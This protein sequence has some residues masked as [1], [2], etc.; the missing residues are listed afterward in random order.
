[1]I[2]NIVSQNVDVYNIFPEENENALRV[3]R[4]R[5]YANGNRKYDEA[6]WSIDKAYTS[7]EFEQKSKEEL[8]TWEKSSG[9][10]GLV[11][12][13]GYEVIDVDDNQEGKLIYNIL[14]AEGLSFHGI[15]TPNGYQFIFKANQISE[16]QAA[17]CLTLAGFEV[18]YR[19]PMKGYI[20]L[21]RGNTEDREWI[22]I[23]NS[24]LSTTPYFFKRLKHIK[25]RPFSLPISEGSR[26]DTLFKHLCRLVEFNVNKD[27]IEQVAY[28]MNKYL[29]TPSMDDREVRKTLNSALKNKP[30]GN[31]YNQH[32]ERSES[33]K[34]AD[35]SGEEKLNYK[36]IA[37]S[38]I[39]QNEIINNDNIFFYF[40][41]KTGIWRD[42][43][44]RYF[45]R[46]ISDFLGDKATPKRVS[47]IFN[48]MK[49]DT[50]EDDLSIT[51]Q[52]MNKKPKAVVFNNGT[53][54]V[55]KGKFV[56]GFEP[57]E[58]NTV[59]IDANFNED[60]FHNNPVPTA[61]MEFLGNVLDPQEVQFVFE[62]I[63]YCMIKGYDIQKFVFLYGDGDN[64]KSTLINLISLI[65]GQNNV[66]SVSLRSLQTERFSRVQ[67]YNKLFNSVADISDDFYD[68]SDFIKA[69]TGDDSIMVEYKGRDGFMMRNFAKLM[70]SCNKLPSFKDNTN[71]LNRRV[72]ILPMTRVPK[73]KRKIESFFTE[74]ER[75]RCLIY[76]LLAIQQVYS[77]EKKFTISER[78]QKMLEDWAEE[79]DN[80]ALFLKDCCEMGSVYKTKVRAMYEEYK[81][82]CRDNNYKPLSSKNFKERM[83]KNG[84][85]ST[86]RKEG[87]VYLEVRFIGEY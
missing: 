44:D 31:T 86:R 17:D 22:H 38:F 21:P 5:G 8:L 9:W 68:S 69:L 72:I 10:L 14:H 46:K 1:M 29:I 30:S 24:E 12:P 83:G 39:E 35:N 87:N 65:L 33:I 85:V 67:L 42:N 43:A 36:G 2:T 56:S 6:K 49:I 64:G 78:M 79:N 80:V 51:Y 76:S 62:W 61:T 13:R 52:D 7:S 45:K 75:E 3:I 53:F 23:E 27:E 60:A 48:M 58:Y 57:K 37:R 4:L 71:G 40:N 50:Y 11:I 15:K 32:E 74:E 70:F 82:Y 63:G 55:D 66:S 18:D 25:E 81:D 16:G 84:I 59:K 26:N 77:N 73:E 28:F 19:L 41:Q 54:Y 34:L 20:V 47:D